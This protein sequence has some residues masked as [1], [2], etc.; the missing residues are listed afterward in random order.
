[1]IDPEK[2]GVFTDEIRKLFAKANGVSPS[3]FSF[4]LEGG[5]PNCQGLGVVYTDLA[6]MDGYKSPCDECKGRAL[7]ARPEA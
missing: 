7:P 2:A 5:L 4:Q 3:L 6:F 1:M